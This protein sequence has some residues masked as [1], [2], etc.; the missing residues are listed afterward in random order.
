MEDP[1]RGNGYEWTNVA[2]HGHK[3]HASGHAAFVNGKALAL[4]GVN[5]QTPNPAGGEIL[6]D[7]KGAP[8]GLLRERAQGVA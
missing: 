1:G 5:T 3:L 2:N 6:K 4:A 8:T 7:A